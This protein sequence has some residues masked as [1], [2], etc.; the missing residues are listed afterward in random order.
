MARLGDLIQDIAQ[1]PPDLAVLEITGVTC[2]PALCRP[3]FLYLAAESECVDSTNL[4]LRLDG[5]DPAFIARA[6]ANGAAII[7]TDREHEL[8]IASPSTEP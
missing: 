5:R 4:G 2:D 8:E 6:V 1:I 3:G 7:L